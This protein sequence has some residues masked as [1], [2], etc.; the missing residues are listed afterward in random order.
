MEGK[1][2]VKVGNKEFHTTSDILC[3]KDDG[4]YFSALLRFPGKRESDGSFFIPR[5]PELFDYVL[6]FLIHGRLFPIKDERLLLKLAEE[7]NYYALPTLGILVEDQLNS[8][9]LQNQPR[10]P[11]QQILKLK[12]PTE[13]KDVWIENGH[14]WLWVVKKTNND[15]FS[16]TKRDN[17]VSQIFFK[18]SGKYFLKLKA[19]VRGRDE[20]NIKS[21]RNKREWRED[22]YIQLKQTTDIFWEINGQP[23]TSPYTFQETRTRRSNSSLYFYQTCNPEKKWHT[24]DGYFGV[25]NASLTI[26]FLGSQ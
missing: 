15:V 13:K 22:G 12:F 14:G 4:S 23:D 25:T 26:I 2:V 5:E 19:H 20:S 10:E 16:F 6:E 7:A 24:P 21:M 11:V 17:Y 3:S 1:V 9:Q 18:K 8:L